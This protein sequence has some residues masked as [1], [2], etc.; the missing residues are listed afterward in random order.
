MNRLLVAL[1]AAVDALVAAV[2][3]VAAALAPLAVL[4]VLALGSTADWGALWPA[5]VRVW[6]LGQ[7]VPVQ[8]TLPADY[9]NAAGIS[10]DAGTFWLSL[11][12]LAFAGFTAISA[13]RCGSRAAR[14]GAWPVGVAAGA[15]VTFVV[16]GVLWRTSGNPIAAIYGWQAL[17]LP[18]LVFTVPALLGALVAAW[19]HGD[20]GP[21]DALRDRIDPLWQDVTGA[22]ARG[23][24]IAVA[25]FVG[26]GALLVAVATVLRG[27]D[28]IALFEAA[29]VDATGAS[30]VAVGQLAYLPTL[31]IW[32]AAFAAGPGFA[33]GTGT[34]VSPA[35]TELGV[36]PGIPVLAVIPPSTTPC[37]LL[38]TLLVIAVG[39]I[40]GTGA[41]AS[42]LGTTAG[43]SGGARAAVLAALIVGSA[44]GSAVL[45][46]LA[47]GSAGPGRLA[48]V[49]PSAGPV[50][51]AVGVELLIGAAI[52]LFGPA[53]AAD[54]ATGSDPVRH[55]ASARPSAYSEGERPLVSAPA[56]PPID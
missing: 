20:D 12:P 18:T 55:V 54:A 6:Q 25:G 5:S 17:I 24:G 35:G 16:A 33:F 53:R 46:A 9:L 3:G 37:L 27:G 42:L 41:R 13:W 31:V 7:L 38:L 8:I 44:A 43:R 23:I 22:A 40:A 19:R 49:G 1:L 21:V 39:C 32:G 48:D 36:V 26:V 29:H 15:L 14:A 30:I 52:A 50:A 47:S 11:A 51:L 4:W 2:V 56:T 34:A 10:A 28:V 45:A